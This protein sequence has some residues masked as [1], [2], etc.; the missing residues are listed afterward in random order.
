MSSIAA[1]PKARCVRVRHSISYLATPN[2]ALNVE[3]T[4]LRQGAAHPF[5]LDVLADC[6][7]RHQLVP[8]EHVVLGLVRGHRQDN[9]AAFTILDLLLFQSTVRD[10]GQEQRA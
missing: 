4:Q 7:W 2:A 8:F 1:S 5:R 9:T 6:V 10:C 3:K